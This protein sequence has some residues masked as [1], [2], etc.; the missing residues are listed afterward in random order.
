MGAKRPLL[1]NGSQRQAGKIIPQNAAEV[2]TNVIHQLQMKLW[3][4][5]AEAESSKWA[6]TAMV[7]MQEAPTAVDIVRD[8]RAQR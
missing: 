1:C 4:P 3:Q 7:K 8:P 5:S 2:I 6:C